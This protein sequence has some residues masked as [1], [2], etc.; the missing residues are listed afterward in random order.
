MQLIIHGKRFKEYFLLFSIS[1]GLML[2]PSDMK[3]VNV[4]IIITL[5]DS[6][7]AS[8]SP[9]TENKVT[10][11]GFIYDLL[12]LRDVS[13]NLANFLRSQILLPQC[14]MSSLTN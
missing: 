1:T 14:N 12:V 11:D 8:H 2:R 3:Q 5:M 6:L 4:M 9:E 7:F 10:Q 13:W